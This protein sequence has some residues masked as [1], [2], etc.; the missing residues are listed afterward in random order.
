MDY[1]RILPVLFLEYLSISLARSLFPSFIVHA[2]GGYSYLILGIVETVKG[3]FSFLCCPLIGRISDNIGRKYCILA[4][5]LGTTFPVCLM[6]FTSNMYLYVTAVA[7]SG[8]FAATFSLTFAY[9]SDCV[10]RDKCAASYGLALATFGL[11]FTVGPIAGGYLNA[12]FGT[13]AVFAT[14]CILVVLNTL[15]I[16]FFLPETI[17]NREVRLLQITYFTVF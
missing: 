6:A 12:S 11:S 5:M 7:I 17:S 16:L 1:K 8:I 2:F 3:F 4:S 13:E 9:I 14:S 10:D 15:Y